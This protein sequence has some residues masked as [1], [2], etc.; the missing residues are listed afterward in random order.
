MKKD[1]VVIEIDIDDE[2]DAE[3]IC[4][5]IFELKYRVLKCPKKYKEI[6]QA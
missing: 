4:S 1:K 6:F 3:E 2:N 5:Y